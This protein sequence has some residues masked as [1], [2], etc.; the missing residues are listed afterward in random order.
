M[1]SETVTYGPLCKI[2][3]LPTFR[4]GVKLAKYFSTQREILFAE[5]SMTNPY[6]KFILDHTSWQKINVFIPDHA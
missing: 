2:I 5:V 6:H 3:S 4:A 1:E